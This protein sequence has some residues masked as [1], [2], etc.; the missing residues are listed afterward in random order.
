M[1]YNWALNEWNNKKLVISKVTGYPKNSTKEEIGLAVNALFAYNMAV[2]DKEKE[3]N[4]KKDLL[5]FKMK[6]INLTKS[7]HSIS[8]FLLSYIYIITKFI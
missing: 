2:L 1:A 6:N 4:Y 7:I 3:V 5:N 8:P